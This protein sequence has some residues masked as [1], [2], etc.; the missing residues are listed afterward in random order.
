MNHTNTQYDA[1]IA[2]CRKIYSNKTIDYGSSWRVLRTISVTDQLFI[3]AKRIR[4][5]QESGTQ[6]IGDDIA[7]EFRA[8]LN[9]AV[10]GIIQEKL[11]SADELSLTVEQAVQLYDGVVSDARRLMQDKSHDYGE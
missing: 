7:S 10:I 6:K 2:A 9:Y 8:I 3:K 4:T 1:V 11:G 5:I